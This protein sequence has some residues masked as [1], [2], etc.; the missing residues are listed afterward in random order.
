M[1]FCVIDLIYDYEVVGKMDLGVV[2]D[3]VDNWNI[4]YKVCMVIDL[5]V[6]VWCVYNFIY[7]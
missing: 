2:R 7:N 1:K 6:F 5:S 4:F 3:M